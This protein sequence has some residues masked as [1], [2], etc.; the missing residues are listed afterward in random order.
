VLAV[1]ALD[2]GVRGLQFGGA[3]TWIPDLFNG[4]ALIL[5][6][7]MARFQRNTARSS[8]IRRSLRLRDGEH[9]AAQPADPA[10]ARTT[11]DDAGTRR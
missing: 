4:A 1:Y 2:V 10:L 11:A 9:A 8:A 3:P 6:V 7:G 5:A